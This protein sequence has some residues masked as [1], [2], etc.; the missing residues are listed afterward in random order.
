MA[1]GVVIV[2]LSLAIGGVAQLRGLEN[3]NNLVTTGLYSKLRHPI[4][5]G[6]IFWI[7]GWAIY[8]GAI[9][10]LVIGCVGIGNILYW[11]WLEEKNLESEYCEVYLEYHR[12]TWF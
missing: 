4:Y 9:V 7:L 5:T 2:G 1:L 11:R 10:S 3:I 6:F 12:G 8:H